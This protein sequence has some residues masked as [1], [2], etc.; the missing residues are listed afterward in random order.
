LLGVTVCVAAGDNGSADIAPGQA[1]DGRAHADF[2]ASSPHALACGGTRLE[3]SGTA[4]TSEVVWNDGS[5]GATGGGVSDV[6]DIPSWQSAANVPVSVNPGGRV[7]RG[8]PD[9]AGDADPAT[10]YRIRVDGVDTTFGGTSAVAPL[11][12]ALIA[13]INAAKGKPAGFVNP[14]L[15]KAAGVCNDITQGNNGSFAASAGWDA[16]TGLGSPNGQKV[17]GAL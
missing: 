12:A 5:G 2:P 9:V 1:P 6:F 8:L 4:I 15:Y 13:R 10:G 16:C 14:K 7:G 11:W 3:G 17:A